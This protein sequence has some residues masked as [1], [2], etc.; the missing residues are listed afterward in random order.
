MRKIGEIIWMDQVDSTNNMAKCHIDEIPDM[1][2]LSAHCQTDGRGQRGN[3]WLTASG[4]NLT[5]SLILK[6]APGE[7]NSIAATD[8]FVLSEMIAASLVETLG[9]HG[10]HAKIKWPNDIYVGDRKICGIL[11]E[12][13]LAGK[14]LTSSVIG[15]GLNVNQLEFDASIHPEAT[16]IALETGQE[17]VLEELLEELLDTVRLYTRFLDNPN[18]YHKLDRIYNG[19]LYRKDEEHS[20]RMKANGKTFDGTIRSVG[21][22]GLLRMEMN[23]GETLE[24]AFNEISYVI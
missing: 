15:V 19:F 20:Y 14:Y 17:T 21:P 9:N 12:N 3:R 16:S 24:F 23:E 11:I 2:V 10:L 8:Q 5:F 22:T 18:E 7:R 6:S 4:K 13:T 1:T